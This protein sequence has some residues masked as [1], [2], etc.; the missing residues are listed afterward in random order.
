MAEPPPAPK[1][2]MVGAAGVS[3]LFTRSARVADIY[4][5]AYTG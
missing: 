3:A 4:I 1:Q 2:H 5:R